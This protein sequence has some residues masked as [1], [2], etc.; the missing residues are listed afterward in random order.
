M[1]DRGNRRQTN[2]GSLIGWLIFILLFAGGPL[3]R[4]LNQALGGTVSIPSYLPVLI[5]GGL[6][7]LSILVPII[8]AFGGAARRRGDDRLPTSPA[9]P[10]TG[11]VSAPMP[12][13]GSGGMTNLPT[14]SI[15]ASRDK[16]FM[17]TTPKFDPLINPKIIG[18]AVVGLL[19]I[20]G[21]ALLVL[22]GS[23][24]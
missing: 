17:P 18:V 10:N 7:A 3:L 14:R 2:W 6:V 12:P 1:D 24:P 20:G 9:P 22:A 8:R 4:L 11:P 21:L 15:S 16:Q 23:Q 19:I 13:F 5:I